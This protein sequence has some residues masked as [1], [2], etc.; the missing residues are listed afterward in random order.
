MAETIFFLPSR[1]RLASYETPLVCPFCGHERKA[2][3]QHMMW[4]DGPNDPTY[5][6][7]VKVSVRYPSLVAR[8]DGITT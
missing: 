1:T 3:D 4:F 5:G 2:G 7:T 8:L 6:C